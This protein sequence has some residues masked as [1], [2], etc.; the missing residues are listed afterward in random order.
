M[1]RLLALTIT[2]LFFQTAQAQDT[3]PNFTLVERGNKVIV[4]WV[5]PYPNCIQ[6][7]VQRSYDSLRYFQTVY[8][9]VSPQLPQNGFTETKMPT[10]RIFYRIFYVLQGGSYFFT[11]SQRVGGAFTPERT[12]SLFSIGNNQKNI[13]V[14]LRGSVFATLPPTGYRFFRD[15]ILKNTRDT[16]FALNDTT[17]QLLPYSGPEYYRAS[18]YVYTMRDGVTI[19]L[20]NAA[21][22][23]YSLKFFEEDGSPLFNIAHV[24]E[25][26]LILDKSNFFHAGWFLFE[27]YEDDR[28]KEKNKFFISKDF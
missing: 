23:K 28:L 4:S 26:Q 11:K 12:I 15:S 27:L 24:K 16:I 21:S 9:A 3:L 7:N 14:Q 8:S 20:P 19:S 6:L 18:M 1:N 13:T 2:I 5:N 25:P 22:R 17:I 10:N